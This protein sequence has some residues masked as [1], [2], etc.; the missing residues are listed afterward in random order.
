VGKFEN[1]IYLIQVPAIVVQESESSS[2]SVPRPAFPSLD[3]TQ[4][5][6]DMGTGYSPNPSHIGSSVAL[7]SPW[8]Q[9]SETDDV[10]NSP[11][12][13]WSNIGGPQSRIATS[14]GNS[15]L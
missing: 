11:V 3:L 12:R 4:M 9:Q 8:T 2:L 14:A 1:E 5:R 13:T 6:D 10:A 15:E 7:Q